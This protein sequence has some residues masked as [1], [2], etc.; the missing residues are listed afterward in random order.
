MQSTIISIN[1]GMAYTVNNDVCN[2]STAM[3]D[4]SAPFSYSQDFWSVFDNAVENPPGTYTVTVFPVVLTLVTVNGLPTSLNTTGLGLSTII[5]ITSYTN[6]A[7]PFS[8]FTLPGA[9]DA[10][11]CN[12]CYSSGAVAR[13]SL[14]LLIIAI[15]LL[16]SAM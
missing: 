9:C 7:P 11:T 10:F 3:T 14:L 2:A 1:D 15:A 6:S 5:T 13:G 4:P 16:F 8:T 12:S